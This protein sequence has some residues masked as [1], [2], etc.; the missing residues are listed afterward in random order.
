LARHRDRGSEGDQKKADLMSES[1]LSFDRLVR[2]LLRSDN[3]A[4]FASSEVADGASFIASEAAASGCVRD[5][6]T[7]DELA[8]AVL[9]GSSSQ[10]GLARM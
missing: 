8:N 1:A 4:S 5:S 9:G 2:S 6:D 7:G 10:V 3:A